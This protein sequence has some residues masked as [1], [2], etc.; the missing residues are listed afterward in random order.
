MPDSERPP[1][2]SAAWLRK[3][4]AVSAANQMRT[5]T[6]VAE[7]VEED[8]AEEHD[9]DGEPDPEAEAAGDLLHDG[10]DDDGDREED[11]GLEVDID[12]EPASDGEGGARGL[13]GGG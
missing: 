2:E 10:E 7:L 11:G 3:P 5:L 9:E 1:P 8:T 4:R 12:A 13:R 6:G